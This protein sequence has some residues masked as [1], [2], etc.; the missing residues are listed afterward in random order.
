MIVGTALTLAIFVAVSVIVARRPDRQTI[1][2]GVAV[3]ALT[4]FVAPT[5]V[6]ERYLF[7]LVA[8]GAILAVVSVRWAVAYLLSALATFANMYFVLTT[9]Y[10]NN[11]S[12]D[13]WLGIGPALGSFPVVA[14]AAVIQGAVF[15]F[16]LSEL[17]ASATRRR[18]W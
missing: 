1:L 16:A 9:L 10:P 6:H 12:I 17:R 8:L 14:L 13:D 7:P 4:F 11:P 2:V 15:L 18:A 5:R 3:L